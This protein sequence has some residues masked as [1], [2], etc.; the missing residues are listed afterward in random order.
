MVKHVNNFKH[1]F[2]KRSSWKHS[3]GELYFKTVD[4]MIRKVTKFLSLL[5]CIR[6]LNITTDHYKWAI[7]TPVQEVAD[8][9]EQINGKQGNFP[10]KNSKF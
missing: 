7:H 6:V 10:M 4:S 3:I 1:F 9:V 5:Y 8:I 2:S